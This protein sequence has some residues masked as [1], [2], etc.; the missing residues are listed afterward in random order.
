MKLLIYILFVISIYSYSFGSGTAPLGAGSSISA[1]AKEGRREIVY[2]KKNGDFLTGQFSSKRLESIVIYGTQLNA[3]SII[4]RE[5]LSEDGEQFLHIA[6][7]DKYRKLI[8]RITLFIELQEGERGELY[9]VTTENE[10]IALDSI[11]FK[12]SNRNKL[13]AYDC[14]SLEQFVYINANS[15]NLLKLSN[16]NNK[17]QSLKLGVLNILIPVFGLFIAGGLSSLI[18]DRKQNQ[19]S[20]IVK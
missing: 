2:L 16:Q 12:Y 13:Q 1:F 4:L 10:L 14:T 20:R 17:I 5:V 3:F 18:Q 8:T 9:S 6:V 7:P 19:S 11:S 15:T